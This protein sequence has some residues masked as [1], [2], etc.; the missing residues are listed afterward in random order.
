MSLPEADRRAALHHG[1]RHVAHLR[2]DMETATMAAHLHAR[3]PD[4]P[5]REYLIP[6][7]PWYWATRE[8]P[9]PA[10][11]RCGRLM[12]VRQPAAGSEDDEG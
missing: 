6:T 4:C 7:R 8:R 1:I 2:T 3:C 12:L 5:P 9:W 10:C 11:P